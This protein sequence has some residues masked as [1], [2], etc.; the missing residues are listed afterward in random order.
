MKYPGGCYCGQIRYK[1]DLQS[2]DEARTS[3]CHCKSCK[4][5][6]GTGFGLTTKIPKGTLRLTE[7][8]PKE[9]VSNNGSTNLRREFC[10]MCGTGIL[11]YGEE[12][13]PKFRYVMTGTFD[14]PGAFPPKGEFFCR[15]REKWMPE[16]SNIF[17]K[18]EIK[19]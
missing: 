2:L 7:G 10:G 13:A 12:A 1:V 15:D 9:H 11:E 18:Q 4:R 8:T 17:H 16:I 3:I 14:Q 19:E 6:F 5:Y